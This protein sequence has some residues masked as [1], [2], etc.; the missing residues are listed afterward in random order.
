MILYPSPVIFPNSRVLSRSNDITS[1]HHADKY[2]IE[3]KRLHGDLGVKEQEAGGD[4]ILLRK[5][6]I[7][8]NHCQ[9][10]NRF[11]QRLPPNMG[12]KVR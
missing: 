2:D 8:L 11:K 7:R 12:E 4:V 9:G 5:L 10:I 1:L 6:N 3:S